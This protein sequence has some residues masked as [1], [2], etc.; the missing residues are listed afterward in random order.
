M[1]KDLIL[2]IKNWILKI[3][4]RNIHNKVKTLKYGD[5]FYYHIKNYKNK[6]TLIFGVDF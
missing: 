5:E 1:A 4:Y 6:S 2:Q 3:K